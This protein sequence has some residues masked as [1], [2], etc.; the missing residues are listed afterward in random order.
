MQSLNT[1]QLRQG[2]LVSNHGMLIRLGAGHVSRSHPHDPTPV[3]VFEGHVENADALCDPAS[4]VY[5]RFIASFLRGANARTGEVDRWTIQGNAYARWNVVE[6]APTT[7]GVRTE[8][9]S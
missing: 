7:T 6:V 9:A 4:P 2:D 3:V 8:V 5:D 1:L